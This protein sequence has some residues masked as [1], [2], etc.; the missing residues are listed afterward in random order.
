MSSGPNSRRDQVMQLLRD[1]AEALS[2]VQIATDLNVHP[3]TARFHLQALV[4]AE[5]VEPVE[6]DRTAP[7]R[8]PL[9]F[10]AVPGMDPAGPRRYQLLAEILAHSLADDPH[11]QARA[12]EAGRA[13]G[14]SLQRTNADTA[15]SIDHLVGVLDDLGFAPA[16]SAAGERGT[17]ELRHCPFLEVARHRSDVI[18]PVHLG[19]MQGALSAWDAPVTVIQLDPFPEPDRCLAH[20]G[21]VEET[22]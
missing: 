20:L 13:W 10:R 17:V 5:R 22:R 11:P 16:I 3:N 8:P 4:D 21:P 2:I 6:A 12:I 9:M 14:Q 15:D 18:C 1:S 19:I 7:G